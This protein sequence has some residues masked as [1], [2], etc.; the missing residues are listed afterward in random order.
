MVT[1]STNLTKGATW[2][3]I[4]GLLAGI[5]TQFVV[6]KE[7][8]KESIEI[9]EEHINDRIQGED[10]DE[11]HDKDTWKYLA[12]ALLNTLITLSGL[13]TSVSIGHYFV[14]TPADFLDVRP[15]FQAPPEPPG[16][17]GEEPKAV[18]PKS[19]APSPFLQTSLLALL[20]FG[21]SA[22]LPGRDKR[23][24]GLAGTV[25]EQA[26]RN[27][28]IVVE[29]LQLMGDHI[30]QDQVNTI[31][32]QF[33][34]MLSNMLST[35]IPGISTVDHSTVIVSNGLNQAY[36]LVQ[37]RGGTSVA[38]PMIT[39]SDEVWQNIVSGSG[40]S[41]GILLGSATIPQ[42]KDFFKDIIRQIIT[43]LSQDTL[44]SQQVYEIL[45]YL[46]T[47]MDVVSDKTRGIIEELL[48]LINDIKPPENHILILA[49]EPSITRI[50]G[51]VDI[52]REETE[53]EFDPTMKERSV[54]LSDYSITAND[55]N[56][57]FIAW[58][59]ILLAHGMRGLAH[60]ISI[61]QMDDEF[62]DELV[63]LITYSDSTTYLTSDPVDNQI[64]P[65]QASSVPQEEAFSL[66]GQIREDGKSVS[67]QVL[68]V[69]NS[70]T[71]LLTGQFITIPDSPAFP[72]R[73]RLQAID[74][75]HTAGKPFDEIHF[76][77]PTKGGRP[78][79]KPFDSPFKS[80]KWPSNV[81]E[82]QIEEGWDR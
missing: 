31:F 65:G 73:L 45:T 41:P 53:N 15:I 11:H 6:N 25:I 76:S 35:V 77:T 62:S 64:V 4:G 14:A 50:F 28:D 55:V 59:K 34:E 63:Y 13:Y 51:L 19:E 58:V 75:I 71:F 20:Q 37:P 27:S 10:I 24:Q 30:T 2:G 39:L 60:A 12:N 9:S 18:V 42:G 21:L 61:E 33:T 48:K 44:T 17:P 8:I 36:A 47:M 72:T 82:P 69:D 38:L 3:I 40:M 16:E 81:K 1:L 5:G 54:L 52:L 66:L 68:A 79:G 78:E 49:H 26:L 43:L 29:L 46:E 7:Q 74:E 67:S 56:P 22:G 57:L 23:A 70:R 80:P 32:R